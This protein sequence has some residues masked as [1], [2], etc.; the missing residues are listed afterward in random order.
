MFPT[1]AGRMNNNHKTVA[2]DRFYRA[3]YAIQK[4]TVSQRR[5]QVSTGYLDKLAVSVRSAIRKAAQ[6]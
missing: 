6:V 3:V 1:N 4:R 2:N 5:I